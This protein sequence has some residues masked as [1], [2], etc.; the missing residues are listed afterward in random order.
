MT[1]PL[2][3]SLRRLERPRSKNLIVFSFMQLFQTLYSPSRWSKFA[4]SLSSLP[5]GTL[6]HSLVPT[7]SLQPSHLLESTKSDT[8]NVFGMPLGSDGA[9]MGILCGDSNPTTKGGLEEWVRFGE[10]LG[11]RSPNGDSWMH[12]VLSCR[13]WNDRPYERYEGPWDVK[14]GLRKTRNKVLWIGN[15]FDK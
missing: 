13:G 1:F 7:P 10:K 4:N 11:E 3:V 6:L 15:T 2:Y 9:S 5:N 14:E 12:L 8:D